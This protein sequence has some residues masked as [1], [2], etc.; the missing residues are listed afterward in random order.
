[1]G[2]HTSHQPLNNSTYAR[3]LIIESTAEGTKM[4]NLSSFVIKKTIAGIAGVSK[5]VKELRNGNLPFEVT[6][7]YLLF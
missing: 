4:S 3:V 5:P 7:P 6:N 1:M 2:E